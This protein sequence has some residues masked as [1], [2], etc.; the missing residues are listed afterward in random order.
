MKTPETLVN[1]VELLK[2]GDQNAF[3]KVYEESYKYLHTCVIHILK[4]E[5]VA[6]DMLQDTYVEIYKNIQQLKASEDF[7]SWAATIANRKCFAYIKKDKEVLV[8]QTSDDEGN[9]RDFFEEISDDESFIPENIFDNKEKV[10]IIRDIIDGLTKEQRACV[11]G[12]YYNEQKQDE[13]AQLLGIPTNTV[14]SHLNRAKAKIK[15]AVGEVEKKQGIKLYSF[16]PFM[17][18]LFADEV[19][20]Y[21]AS[22]SIPAFTGVAA[23]AAKV[24]TV[25]KASVTA[26][27]TKVIVA[28]VASFAI[29]GT[30][31]G[32]TLANRN[33]DV[34]E[35]E[36]VV[37]SAV[38]SELVEEPVEVVPEEPV[39]AEPEVVE[40]E[41]IEEAA[42]KFTK[43]C[44]IQEAGYDAA[45]S[46]YG[47]VLI[48]KKDGLYG[49]VDYEMNEILPCRYADYKAPNNKGYFVMTDGATQHLFSKTGEEIYST[50]GDVTA[51]GDCFI[52]AAKYTEDFENVPVDVLQYY[53]YSGKLLLETSMGEEMPVRAA[54]FHDGVVLLRRYDYDP[55]SSNCK[56]EVGKLNGDGDVIWQTE[57]D[58]PSYSYYGNDGDDNGNG[59]AYGFYSSQALLSGLNNGYYVTYHKIIEWGVMN[60]YDENSEHVATFDIC[61]MGQDGNYSEDNHFSDNN[62]K[63]YYYDGAYN[64]NR[65]TLMVIK[66]G[67]RC[68][69]FDALQKKALANYEYICL[70][71]DDVMLVEDGENW[72]YINSRGEV[73]AMYDDASDFKNGHAL[74]IKDGKACLID[75]NLNVVEE[76]GE[77]DGVSV[78]GEMYGVRKGDSTELYWGGK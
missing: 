9:E 74:I 16:A 71:E 26:L 18:L 50:N 27:K 12:F 38:V 21:A 54:G 68:I 2:K 5:D 66:S 78:Y 62:L 1:E 33:A 28:A 10:K 29:I 14:K 56:M 31:V 49:A 32:V 11:I 59:A 73:L 3:T 61:G 52:V 19:K 41:P 46:A 25:A 42:F 20:T 77:A 70:C 37:V 36:S 51:T 8:N 44:N 30:I 45:K 39:A 65:G 35:P 7:L 57:Y 13:I 40:E 34:K 58:G 43:I 55:V 76:I 53:D 15:D 17:L 63:G 47:G 6:L 67:D 23:S 75:T 72:G 48:V 64:Y 4:D 22:A 60:M 69:L 24:G